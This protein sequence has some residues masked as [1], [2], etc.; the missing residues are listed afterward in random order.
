MRK[1]LCFY[2]SVLA[3]DNS[4]VSMEQTSDE[5]SLLLKVQDQNE[6]EDDIFL[7]WFPNKSLSFPKNEQQKLEQSFLELGDSDLKLLADK[8]GRKDE[9]GTKYNI[10]VYRFPVSICS[11][12][13]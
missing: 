11:K 5:S 1:V 10:S 9:Y 3:V 6:D 2:I 12:V 7:S 4:T 8:K 13:F